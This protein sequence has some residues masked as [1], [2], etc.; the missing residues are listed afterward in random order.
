MKLTLMHIPAAAPMPWGWQLRSPQGQ[1]LAG[2]YEA[3]WTAALAAA[4]QMS[5]IFSPHSNPTA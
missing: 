4:Q 5:R 3:T 2:G 1:L